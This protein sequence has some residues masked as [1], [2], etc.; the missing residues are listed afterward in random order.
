MMPPPAGSWG[1]P[2]DMLQSLPSYGPDV[3]KNRDEARAIMRKLGYGPDHRL[4]VT[5]K[6][7]YR[8]QNTK[9]SVRRRVVI[10]VPAGPMSAFD[11]HIGHRGHFTMK[12]IEAV[13][14]DAGLD[15]A[16]VRGAGF[17]FFNLYRLT[18]IARGKRLIAD[19][20]GTDPAS[21]PLAARVAIRG[22]SW[23]FRLNTD[24]TGLGWQLVAVGIQPR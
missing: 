12:R 18:V 7:E 9:I 23:L 10:T 3:A 16:E 4:A 2:L 22:F 8:V 1:M 19:A 20:G 11:R 17:P 5:V 6:V 21:L 24:R 14:R 13:L 15:V